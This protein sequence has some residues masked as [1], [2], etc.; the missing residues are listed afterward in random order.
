MEATA[1]VAV[2]ADLAQAAL[3]SYSEAACWPVS[4][5]VRAAGVEF[6]RVVELSF[7]LR[8]VFPRLLL[9]SVLGLDQTG[10]VVYRE[11]AEFVGL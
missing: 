7:P 8:R 9:C 6:E 5:W 10:G 1:A 3:T 11:G 2:R 4:A